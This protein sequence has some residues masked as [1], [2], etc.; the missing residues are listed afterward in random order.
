VKRIEAKCALRVLKE[1]AAGSVTQEE[2][3]EAM[4]EIDE[5]DF[6]EQTMLPNPFD[7][8]DDKDGDGDEDD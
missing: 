3:D 2:I 5:T 8:P 1:V 6:E 4:A 7:R